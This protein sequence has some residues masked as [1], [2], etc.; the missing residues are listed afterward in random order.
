[1]SVVKIKNTCLDNQVRRMGRGQGGGDGMVDANR[2]FCW[3]C[4]L[5]FFSLCF[6]GFGVTQIGSIWRCL[7]GQVAVFSVTVAGYW[8]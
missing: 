1:M 7:D 6:A 5:L 2:V 8:G 4:R 3:R